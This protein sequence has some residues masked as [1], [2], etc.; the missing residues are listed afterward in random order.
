MNVDH[1]GKKCI[2]IWHVRERKRGENMETRGL[3]VLLSKTVTV[4]VPMNWSGWPLPSIWTGRLVL[5]WKSSLVTQESF[6]HQISSWELKLVHQISSWD[7]ELVRQISSWDLE[8]IPR[9]S[10]WDLELIDQFSRA[11]L[12]WNCDGP[13]HYTTLLQMSQNTYMIFKR[14]SEKSAWFFPIMGLD[15]MSTFFCLIVFYK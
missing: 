2:R 11:E 8:R 9:M 1:F 4:P 13:S 6:I 7:L 3:N 15:I 14:S 12:I 10:S 5:V